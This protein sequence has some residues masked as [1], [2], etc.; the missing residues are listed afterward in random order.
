MTTVLTCIGPQHP[1]TIWAV[2]SENPQP[3]K[4]HHESEERMAQVSIPSISTSIPFMM[5]WPQKN[6]D[7]TWEPPRDLHYKVAF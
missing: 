6:H 1:T 3:P 5:P 7:E 2:V 4:G